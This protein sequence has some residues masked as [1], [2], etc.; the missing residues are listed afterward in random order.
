MPLLPSEKDNNS[1]SGSSYFYFN[2][3]ES[4]NQTSYM[5]DSF[6]S[7][8]TLKRN[9]NTLAPPNVK[10][11]NISK[12]GPVDNTINLESR[13]STLTKVIVFEESD[14]FLDEDE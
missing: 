14:D 13:D 12:S 4:T 7:H 2:D 6:L 9:T 1:I 8:L 10:P 11:S 3:S 5:R